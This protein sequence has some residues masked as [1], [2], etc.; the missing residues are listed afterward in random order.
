MVT[1]NYHK[2]HI[3]QFTVYTYDYGMPV[4]G[5]RSLTVKEELYR[6]LEELRGDLKYNSLSDVIAHLLRTYEDYMNAL[7]TMIGDLEELKKALIQ[8]K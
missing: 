5:Y 7:T 2:I 3:P 4:K 6:E 8:P 1:E